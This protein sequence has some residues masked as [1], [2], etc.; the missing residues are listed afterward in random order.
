MVVLDFETKSEVDLPNCGVRVYAEDPST[1]ILVMGYMD[2]EEEGKPVHQWFPG[3]PLPDFTG[4]KLYAFNASFEYEIWNHVMVKKYGAPFLPIDR[5][6]DIKALCARYGLPQNLDKACE[7]LKTKYAKLHTGT[8]L[9]KKFCIPPFARTSGK[10]WQDFLT[11]NIYDVKS[12]Y[13]VIKSLPSDKLSASER[14]IF[15]LNWEINLRGI[16]VA[17]D[18][19]HRIY[20]VIVTYLD[21]HNQLLPDLTGGCVTKVTQTKR[22]KDWLNSRGI[23]VDNIRAETVQELLEQYDGNTKYD[24]V[25][26]VLELRAATG[27]SSIGKY[28]RIMGMESDGRMYYNSNYHG[29]HTGRI[30]GSGFQLL[31]LPR[32]SVADPEAEVRAFLDGSIVEHNPVLSGRALVRSMIKARPGYK[33]TVADY[34]SIEYILEMWLAGET[35]A[36]KRFANG[37]DQYKLLAT[38]MYHVDYDEVSKNQRQ[39]GK[40]GIL[41]CGYGLGAQ[42]F[43]RYADQWGVELSLEE[44]RHVVDS[45]RQKYPRVVQLWY[46]LQNSAIA[47]ILAPGSTHTAF[48]TKFKAVK[49]RVGTRWLA[50]TLVSGR[51]MYYRNPRIVDGK[52]GPQVVTEGMNQKTKQWG[53]KEMTPGKWAENVIQAL[54]RDLLYYGKFK[55]REAGYQLI[56]SVYDEV[57]SEDHEDFGS[58]EEFEK[59]MASVPPWAEGLPLRAEGYESPRY[60]KG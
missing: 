50:M 30:T 2:D 36:V 24:D 34:A 29:A 5:W 48:K 15:D 6:E 54:G 52:Y 4:K 1:D 9:I 10:D 19:A 44:A 12:E 51:T 45:Y 3:M 22:I 59:L 23:P 27:L 28:K 35:D 31:N 26:Q 16:P 8:A 43:I 11:Y 49:D 38:L 58:V 21:E 56:G 37:Q 14:A 20:E 60:K 57:L 47:A 40:M 18:E 32:A 55:L 7:V 13:E 39:M 53:L 25:I 41:G 46:E 17:A 33:I 42:G